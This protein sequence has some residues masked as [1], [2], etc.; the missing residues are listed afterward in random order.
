[1]P[2]IPYDATA[3]YGHSER[4]E[5][6]YGEPSI[7]IFA[8]FLHVDDGAGQPEGTLALTLAARSTGAI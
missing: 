1:M 4:S 5:E 2:G 8:P 7:F 6:S 3:Q